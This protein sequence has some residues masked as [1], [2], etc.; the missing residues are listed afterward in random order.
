[1]HNTVPIKHLLNETQT[2]VKSYDRVAEATGENFNIFSILKAENYEVTTH[3]RFIG[4]LLN[5]KGSHGLGDTFLKIFFE[6]FCKE[7]EFDTSSSYVAVEYHIGKVDEE[8]GGRLDILIRDGWEG[9]AIMIENKV[10]AQEGYNQLLRYRNAFPKGMLFYLTLLGEESKGSQPV[11]YSQ[12]AYETDII[13]WLETCKKEAINI[14][15]LRES[16][17]QYIN[18]IKKLT[19]QN[20]NT[21]MNED[22]INIVLRDEDSLMA[23]K[24]LH[25][26]HLPL[27]RKMVREIGILIEERF[28]KE[29]I[30]GFRVNHNIDSAGWLVDI[31]SKEMEK[32]SVFICINFETSHYSKLI[33]GFKNFTDTKPGDL[34]LYEAFKKEFPRAKQSKWYTSYVEFEDYTHWHFDVLS[35]IRFGGAEQFLKKLCENVNLMVKIVE[36]H[37]LEK[38]IS[39]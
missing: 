38:L 3:S 16:L 32:R 12:L 31:S 8:N 35:N 39:N 29:G 34:Q 20:L 11:D 14:P 7:Y 1:M 33:M 2:I 22:L 21:K 19:H 37:N 18:L 15:I 28:K 23:Y 17:T 5:R 13:Q 36:K 6:M 10:Y 27:K 26:L 24:A 4:E 25:D 9:R 30:Q